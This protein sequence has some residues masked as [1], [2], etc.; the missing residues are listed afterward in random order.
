MPLTTTGPSR[1]TLMRLPAFVGTCRLAVL[2]APSRNCE[3]ELKPLPPDIVLVVMLVML[4]L[5]ESWVCVR[6]SGMIVLGCGTDWAWAR[7]GDTA[8]PA[9]SACGN[10]SNR[11]ELRAASTSAQAVPFR[12]D[13]RF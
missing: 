8:R 3:N 4:P 9:P 12:A 11:G 13:A 6:P 1:T 2:P 5:V 10:P 7:L